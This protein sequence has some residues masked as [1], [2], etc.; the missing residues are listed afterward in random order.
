LA[1]ASAKLGACKVTAVDLNPLCVKTALLNVRLNGLEERVRVHEGRAEDHIGEE[2]DLIVA[3]L[4]FGLI[5][6]LLRMGGFRNAGWLI[7]SGL[8]RT[9]WREVRHAL[10]MN[11]FQIERE[12][13]H[14]MTWF[15]ILALR[16]GGSF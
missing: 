10:M 2:R 8:M 13:D 6:A 14:E 11:G 12:W 5:E 1:L 16:Q 15:T 9:Q 7:I 3:N 4:H